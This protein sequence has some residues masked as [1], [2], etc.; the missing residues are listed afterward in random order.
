MQ[1]G[2]RNH[3]VG[4]WYQTRNNMKQKL[5]TRHRE[6]LDV[7]L[8]IKHLRAYLERGCLTIR[9]EYNAFQRI[10]PKAEVTGK[11]AWYRHGLSKLEFDIFC[12]AGLK[13]PAVDALRPP[14]TEHEDQTLLDAKDSVLPT[15]QEVSTGVP[16]K[17]ITDFEIF[18]ESK[19][20]FVP[21]I[22]EVWVISS[23]A[24]DNK[25]DIPTFAEFIS[26]HSTNADCGSMFVSFK[27]PNIGLN[28]DKNGVLVRVSPLHGTSH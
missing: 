3:S 7:I 5:A 20:L 14:K 21:F 25:A 27:K 1:E 6:N 17:E 4:Y 9:T 16:N 23:V 12:S 10:F 8:V 11:L 26:A 15:R 22:P 28:I 24:D 13:H 2:G 19:G 18:E